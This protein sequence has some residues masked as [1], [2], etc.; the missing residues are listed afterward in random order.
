MA[1]SQKRSNRE[2]KKPKKVVAAVVEPTP[3]KGLLASATPA[4]KKK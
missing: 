1:K 3:M 4:K 2:M